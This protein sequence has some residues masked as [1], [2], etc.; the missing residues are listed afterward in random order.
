MKKSLLALAVLGAFAGSAVAQSSVT[1][2]GIADVNINSAKGGTNRLTAMGSGG[3][4][5]SR[6][7]FR[8]TEDL[9]GGLKANFVLEN[10]FSIDTGAPAQTGTTTNTNTTAVGTRLFGRAAWVGLSGGF[11][12]VRLG[13]QLTAIGSLTDELGPFGTKTGDAYAVAGSVGNA[14]YRTDNAITYLSPNFAGFTLNA[15]YSFQVDGA[16]QNKPNQSSGEHFNLAAQFK[17]GPVHLGVGYIEVSD[18]SLATAG[19]QE[20]KGLLAFGSVS[21][22]KYKVRASYDQTDTG[23]VENKVIYGVSLEAPFG[24]VSLSVGIA[25]AE[26]ITGAANV[27]DDATLGIVRAEYEMSK[28][29]ALYTSYTRVSNGTSAALGFNSPAADKNSD[30]FQVGVRHRF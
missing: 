3:L 16:E 4:N 26:D 10:G 14:L 29:T 20:L 25:K 13:R 18:T 7:G 8:G 24:P 12:E 22:G 1:L 17:T 2:Y 28:R 30:L 23:A 6:V 21:F 11:G 19:D 15:Q 9:G 27:D 5:G